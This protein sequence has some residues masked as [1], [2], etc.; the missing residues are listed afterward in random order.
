MYLRAVERLET[1]GGLIQYEISNVARPGR[2]SRHNLKY[3]TGGDWLG[4]GCGAH[5]TV[6]LSAETSAAAGA[7]WK[8]VAG[9][10]EYIGRVTN[11]QDPRIEYGVL[12]AGERLEEALFTGLRLTAGIDAGAIGHRYGVDVFARYGEALAPFVE[13]G[14]LLR[15]GGRLRLTRD[16]MLM[17]NEVMAVFV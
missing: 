6:G 7:R 5:S 17:A 13:A 3:W 2:A 8:N 9:T 12:T 4:F 11:G 16:G 15:E 14:W 1:A 10:E